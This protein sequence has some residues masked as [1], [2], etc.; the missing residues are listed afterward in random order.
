[1][2]PCVAWMK[3]GY[4][5]Y[6]CMRSGLFM[7]VFYAHTQRPGLCMCVRVLQSL[8]Y[9]CVYVFY[10]VW[11]MHVHVLYREVWTMYACVCHCVRWVW[12]LHVQDQGLDCACVWERGVC[13]T[14]VCAL[15]WERWSGL[16]ARVREVETII[17]CMCVS[18]F[19]FGPCTC[20]RDREVGR[21]GLWMRLCVVR[22]I[23]T[24]HVC[25]REFRTMHNK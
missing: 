4:S 20:V 14:H 12:T 10:K 15:E 21:S 6:V 18:E 7:L 24:M 3:T 1:M 19:G 13:T 9:A 5:V 22:E 17:I 8:D 25:V 16:C 23:W 2:Q 11:T